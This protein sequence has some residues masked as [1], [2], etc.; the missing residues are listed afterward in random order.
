[1]A[2]KVLGWEAE[3]VRLLITPDGGS[4]QSPDEWWG[5]FLSAAGRLLEKVPD[6]RQRV[7]AVCCSTQGEGTVP[8]DKDGNAL[9]NCILWMDMRGAPHLKKQ[10]GGLINID[11][12]SIDKV[13]RFVR[14]TG[15]RPGRAHAF[16]SRYTA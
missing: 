12:A 15:G 1:L 10:L 8:V 16:Y 6:A 13:L 14:L 3:P 2:G 7:Q 9:S 4:E 11:G 5:A